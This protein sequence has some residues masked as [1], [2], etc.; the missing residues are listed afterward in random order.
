MGHL[1]SYRSCTQENLENVL[2]VRQEIADDV[3]AQDLLEKELQELIEDE[4][5]IDKSW[6]LLSIL[7]NVL[8]K[9]NNTPELMFAIHGAHETNFDNED[10]VLQYCKSEEVKEISLL[11]NEISNDLF[12]DQTND[13]KVIKTIKELLGKEPKVREIEDGT[14]KEYYVYH[15]EK[16]RAFYKQA[17]SKNLYIVVESEA[18]VIFESKQESRDKGIASNNY[19]KFLLPVNVMVMF[20]IC[21]FHPFSR[22]VDLILLLVLFPVTFYLL[23][24]RI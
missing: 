5:E 17:A 8:A 19:L 20:Y 23:I 21:Y 14:M 9:K 22:T 15:F 4:I 12:W 13:P 16:L 10:C 2:K 6:G 11:L 3:D 18:A 1:V 7:L 24:K